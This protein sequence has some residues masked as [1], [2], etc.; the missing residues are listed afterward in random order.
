MSEEQ[1]ISETECA[2]LDGIR[3]LLQADPRVAFALVFGSEAR[4]AAHAHSDVDIAIGLA[5]GAGLDALTVG[6]LIAKLQA[7]AARPVD[8]VLLDEAPPGLAYRVF[9]DGE[10]IVINDRAALGRRL[11]RAVLEYL[12]F[13]PVEEQFTRAV[14]RS[15]H[16]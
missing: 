13:R 16:G 6:A 5:G 10:P 11:A 1:R 9:R 3:R 2:M 14:L 4:K 15:R 7:A 12:D 8:V